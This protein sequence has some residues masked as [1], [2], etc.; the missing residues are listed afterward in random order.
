MILLISASQVARTVGVSHQHP[1][2][3]KKLE[4]TEIE[5]IKEVKDLYTEKCKTSRKGIKEN[6]NK[7]KDMFMDW[8]D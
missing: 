7:W 5:L 4:K 8:N 2:G 3:M 6:T 1:T